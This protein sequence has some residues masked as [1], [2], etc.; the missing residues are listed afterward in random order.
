MSSESPGFPL[1][2]QTASDGE[3]KHE[4]EVEGLHALQ[5]VCT[6][7]ASCQG[8]A[9]LNHIKGQR[10]G[11]FYFLETES[12]EPHPPQIPSKSPKLS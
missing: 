10:K 1:R 12:P 8:D 7:K 9:D 3:K 5:T 6:E 2:I 4:T 11:L